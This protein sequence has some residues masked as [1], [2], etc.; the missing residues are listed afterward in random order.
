MTPETL[1]SVA[2]TTALLMWIL[3]ALVPGRPWVTRTVTTTAAAAL[4]ALYVALIAATPWPDG[5]GFGSLAQV[6][7]LF[8]VPR[9]LLAGCA[10]PSNTVSRISHHCPRV[11]RL[12]LS[13][14]GQN[15]SAHQASITSFKRR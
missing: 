5:G 15:Q 2:N 12:L 1:F 10:P 6:S 4:A 7:A 9:V 3:L 14:S 8:S 11:G 13:V